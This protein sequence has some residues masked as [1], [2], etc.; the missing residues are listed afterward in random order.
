MWPGATH[1]NKCDPLYQNHF[2]AKHF[3]DT[4]KVCVSLPDIPLAVV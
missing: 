1:E 4:K 3:E 2:V